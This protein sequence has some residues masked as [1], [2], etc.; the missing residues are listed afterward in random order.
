MWRR[1]APAIASAVPETAA[2]QKAA[3][4]MVAL[5]GGGART[6]ANRV[7]F[8]GTVTQELYGCKMWY[9]TGTMEAKEAL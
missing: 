4:Q 9:C 3:E 7:V 6:C 5:V 1:S 2:A 8:C